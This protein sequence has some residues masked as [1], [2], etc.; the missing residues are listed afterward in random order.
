MLTTLL[1]GEQVVEAT[2]T[3]AQLPLLLAQTSNSTTA[4]LG[5]VTATRSV[6]AVTAFQGGQIL[7]VGLV[8]ET[9]SLFPITV[10]QGG[11]FVPLG[12]V[13]AVSTV[14]PATVVT[15]TD[16]FV[17]TGLVTASSALYALTVKRALLTP[18][19]DQ[20]ALTLTETDDQSALDLTP[21]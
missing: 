12:L 7:Q 16:K 19:V 11:L 9:R 8:T 6:Y 20:P 13:T 18:L 21:A 3:R 10:V 2:T 14:Y 5:L 15:P 17:Q 4:T 1:S